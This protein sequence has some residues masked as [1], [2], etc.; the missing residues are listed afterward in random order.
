ME[1]RT[2]F[3]DPILLALT[4]VAGEPRGN[5]FSFRLSCVEAQ[6]S[7]ASVVSPEALGAF[8]TE[9]RIEM[10]IKRYFSL[11]HLGLNDSHCE[12]MAQELARDDA[13]T[14]SIDELALTGNPSIGQQGYEA[15][16]GLL[17]RTFAIG[18]VCVDDQNW[19]STFDL[20]LFMNRACH[21]G[22]FLKNGVFPSKAMWVNFL[23]EIFNTPPTGMK[24]R[25]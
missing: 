25:S 20:V 8:F 9:E 2:G 1:D 24:R 12:A 14:K 21:G 23:A 7:G 10:P 4:P 19:Q 5:I 18:A 11:K 3:L 6:L 17:N 13:L 16:L 15:L 22:R